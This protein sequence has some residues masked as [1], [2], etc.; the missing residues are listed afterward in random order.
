M[1]QIAAVTLALL[2]SCVV[3]DT[4]VVPSTSRDGFKLSHLR[5]TRL[6]V[7]P[8]PRATSDDPSARAILEAFTSRERFLDDVAGALSAGLVEV[9]AA[10]S[11]PAGQVV[12]LLTRTP[13]LRR[14]LDPDAVLGPPDAEGNRFLSTGTGGGAGPALTDLAGIPDLRDVRYLVVFR[15]L[16]VTTTPDQWMA[17]SPNGGATGVLSGTLTGR[18][19]FGVVDLR[20][21]ER[22]WDGAA[23]VSGSGNFD[24]R[25]L[26]DELV[27]SVMD[28]VEGRSRGPGHTRR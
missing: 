21:R 15:D 2:A 13:E 10:P 11:I 19:R 5:R 22:V 23:S 16:A 7:W 6:A 12:L 24:V 26:R 18:L 17:S 8:I 25:E 3:T 28:E 14:F 27:R 4:A 20:S 1:R 9:A